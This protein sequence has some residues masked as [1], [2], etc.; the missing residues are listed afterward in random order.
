MGMPTMG[1]LR[2]LLLSATALG[3]SQSRKRNLAAVPGIS[4]R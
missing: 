4:G 1:A 3:G 2:D